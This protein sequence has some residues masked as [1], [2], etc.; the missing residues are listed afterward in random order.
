MPYPAFP[1]LGKGTFGPVAP[2]SS[3]QVTPPILTANFG[4]RYSQ[5]TGDGINPLPRDFAYRSSILPSADIQALEDFLGDRA[6]YKP[7]TFLIPGEPAARQFTCE[8]WSVDYTT[9][10]FWTLTAT[11]K[12]NF[13]P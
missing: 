10:L 2:G 6:G 8:E 12:E 1:T 3:K 5:R 11:F 4:G 7:F 9:A 13:D